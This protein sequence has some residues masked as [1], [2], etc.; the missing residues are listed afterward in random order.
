[1]ANTRGV[2][3][4]YIKFRL[5]RNDMKWINGPSEKDTVDPVNDAIRKHGVEFEQKYKSDLEDLIANLEIT[6][7]NACEQFFKTVKQLFANGDK[8]WGR[9]IALFSFSGKFAVECHYK[10][11][12][13]VVDS[14]AEWTVSYIEIILA[15]WISSNSG[16]EALIEHKEEEEE[17]EQPVVEVKESIGWFGWVPR[18]FKSKKL[19]KV[20][21]STADELA[22]RKDTLQGSL[23]IEQKK[24]TVQGYLEN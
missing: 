10:E 16:W 23:E 11:I 15:S 8:N 2:V 1:M 9:I 17:P 18:L 5:D 20:T 14:L 21:S 19:D 6:E 3:H 24:D 13:Q 7:G 22:Q 4:D 12:P